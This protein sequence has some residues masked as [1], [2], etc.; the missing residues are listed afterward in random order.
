MWYVIVVE[1]VGL[2]MWAVGEVFYW[3][4]PGD[5]RVV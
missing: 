2:W 1:R 4:V 5:I 3:V